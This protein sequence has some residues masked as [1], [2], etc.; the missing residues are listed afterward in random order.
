M[1]DGHDC[2]PPEFHYGPGCRDSMAYSPDDV[3]T[4]PAGRLA[5]YIECPHSNVIWNQDRGAIQVLG[6]NEA[7]V[8]SVPVDNEQL[9]HALIGN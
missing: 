4:A 9:R 8:A 7:V 5:V 3:F 2:N 1:Y 6:C